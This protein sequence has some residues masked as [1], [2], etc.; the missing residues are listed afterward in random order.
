MT[1][2]SGSG[3]NEK[4]LGSWLLILEANKSITGLKLKSFNT[5]LKIESFNSHSVLLSAS[6]DS[7]SAS[8][9]RIPGMCVAVKKLFLSIAQSQIFFTSLTHEAN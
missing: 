8:T 2:T 3:L 7:A 1:S 9:F 5:S 6:L 4:N